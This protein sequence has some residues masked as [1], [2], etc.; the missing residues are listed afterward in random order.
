MVHE[1]TSPAGARAVPVTGVTLLAS[2]GLVLAAG[3]V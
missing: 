2:A 3:G 1:K